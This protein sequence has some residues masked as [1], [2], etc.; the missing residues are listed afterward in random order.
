M[1]IE[2]IIKSGK[3]TSEVNKIK[4][5]SCV[6]VGFINNDGEE[7]ETQLEVEFLQTREGNEELSE[8]FRSLAA[9]LNTKPDKVIYITV[10]ASENTRRKIK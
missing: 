8:L 1:T 6:N 9:E 7:D 4:R 5:F 2:E 10:V 3:V